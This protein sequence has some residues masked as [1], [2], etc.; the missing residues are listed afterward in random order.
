VEEADHF[1]LVMP[2]P[3]HPQNRRDCNWHKMQCV[4]IGELADVRFCAFGPMSPQANKMD[5]T[6]SPICKLSLGGNF[7]LG[8][9]RGFLWKKHMTHLI[10]TPL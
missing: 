10:E 2:G 6:K 4:L 5:S 1:L 9:F 7:F 3:Y 8:T